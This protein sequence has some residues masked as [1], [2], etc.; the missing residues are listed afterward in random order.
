MLTPSPGQTADPPQPDSHCDVGFQTVTQLETSRKPPTPRT[1][2]PYCEIENSVPPIVLSLRRSSSVPDVH[3]FTSSPTAGKPAGYVPVIC[4]DLHG[5]IDDYEDRLS[6]LKKCDNTTLETANHGPGAE[7]LEKSQDE[8]LDQSLDAESDS[9]SIVELISAGE[10]KLEDVAVETESSECDYSSSAKTLSPSF[11]ETSQSVDHNYPELK[12]LPNVGI[13]S[14]EQNKET[15]KKIKTKNNVVFSAFRPSSESLPPSE[16]HF[17]SGVVRSPDGSLKSSLNDHLNVLQS[18]EYYS[19]E[20]YSSTCDDLLD[21]FQSDF[22][23]ISLPPSSGPEA[24]LPVSGSTVDMITLLQR[25]VG[26]AR[27]LYQSLCGTC[28]GG[29]VKQEEF[30]FEQ[31]DF[32][33]CQKN[34][35]VGCF[36]KLLEVRF[37]I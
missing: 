36:E 32:Y 8:C 33:R 37:Y 22:T 6:A 16:D 17:E 4:G 11:S 35:M 14:Y 23:S 34:R 31:M 28:D 26:F 2:T 1:S 3:G 19:E 27:T 29:E 12:Q 20:Q 21:S 7:I 25:L 5:N 24:S 30:T 10:K 13:S 18:G 9:G 15:N